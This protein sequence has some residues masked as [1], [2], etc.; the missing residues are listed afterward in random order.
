M[1]EITRLR[2][3]KELNMPNYGFFHA[4]P[5]AFISV[6]AAAWDPLPIFKA[7]L[8]EQKEIQIQSFPV[9]RA[10]TD[11]TGVANDPTFAIADSQAQADTIRTRV[12]LALEGRRHGESAEI[13]CGLR[14]EEGIAGGMGDRGVRLG[15]YSLQ[16]VRAVGSGQHGHHFSQ[17]FAQKRIL[18]KALW[19]LKHRIT[20]VHT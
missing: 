12:E 17:S 20:H 19:D 9:T 10:E 6:Q 2:I 1:R 5:C 7:A 18:L 13:H 11:I 3:G 16:L 15:G 8:L 4:E 14:G